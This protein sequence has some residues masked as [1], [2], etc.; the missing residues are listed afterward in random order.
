MCCTRT[1]NV[2]A[3]VPSTC[4]RARYAIAEGSSDQRR[5]VT[6]TATPSPTPAGRANSLDGTCRP[7]RRRR[8]ARRPPSRCGRE[9]ALARNGQVG[10]GRLVMISPSHTRRRATT[11]VGLELNHE[12]TVHRFLEV[13]KPGVRCG[14]AVDPRASVHL[15]VRTR[16]SGGG[17]PILVA[18][19][20][21]GLAAIG[22][23]PTHHLKGRKSM[24]SHNLPE[25]AIAGIVVRVACRVDF[26]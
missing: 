5:A 22:A 7:N 19:S 11:Y 21:E 9:T 17:S 15:S 14:A 12:L 1:I 3:I 20:P 2:T 6:K 26:V 18:R 24:L 4:W 23:P 16:W 25:D 10:S 13:E 8:V